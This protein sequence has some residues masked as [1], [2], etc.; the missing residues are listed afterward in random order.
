[1]LSSLD[2]TDDD[3]DDDDDDDFDLIPAVIIIIIVIISGFI[4]LE[5]VKV[6]PSMRSVTF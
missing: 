6:K 5:N 4:F 2:V 1:M 3:D